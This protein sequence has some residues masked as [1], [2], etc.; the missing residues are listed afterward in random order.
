VGEGDFLQAEPLEHA[1]LCGHSG[2]EGGD[3]VP[4]L[5]ALNI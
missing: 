5:L 4:I 2:D 1:A 3:E